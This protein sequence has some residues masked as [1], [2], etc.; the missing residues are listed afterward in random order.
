MAE[1]PFNIDS[2]AT[3]AVPA[4]NKIS[5]NKVKI[6]TLIVVHPEPRKV[7]SKLRLLAVLIALDVSASILYTLLLSSTLFSD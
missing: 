6:E 3:I 7:R 4:P 5:E 1:Q 2:I